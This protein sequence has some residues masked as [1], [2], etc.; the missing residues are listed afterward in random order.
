MS[1]DIKKGDVVRIS[2]S[3]VQGVVERDMGDSIVIIYKHANGQMLRRKFT[4]YEATKL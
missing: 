2:G 1:D 4:K 3:G